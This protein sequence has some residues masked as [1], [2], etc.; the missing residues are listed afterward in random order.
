M[1]DTTLQG[2]WQYNGIDSTISD[3]TVY[4]EYVNISKD[5]IIIANQGVDCGTVYYLKKLQ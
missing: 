5:S 2:W 4:W 1:S 3:S